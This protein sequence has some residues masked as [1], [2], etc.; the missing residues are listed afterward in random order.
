MTNAQ[1]FWDKTAEKYAKSPVRD[2]ATYQRKLAETRSYLAPHMR[3]LEFGCGTGTTA[4][5]HAPHV[6]HIDALDIAENMLVIGRARAAEAGVENITFSR[7]TLQA[8]NAG[9]A[10]YDAVL[11]L[12]VLHLIEDRDAV[13]AEAYRLLKPGGVFVTSTVCLAGSVLRFLKWLV[14]LGK[15]VG[16]MP[17]V[18]VFSEQEY[19]EQMERAGF[20][21]ESQ[22]RHARDGIAVFMVAVKPE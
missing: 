2:E 1:K 22:W 13:I 21:I 7:G 8:F 20:R 5:H 11:G 6:A 16:L 12:N 3:V 14:P 17:D 18:Y 10:S 15:L 4:I 9:A 19:A